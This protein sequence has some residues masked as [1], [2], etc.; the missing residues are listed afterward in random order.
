MMTAI[1]INGNC[2]ILHWLLIKNATAFRSE[3]GL[4]SLDGVIYYEW[5]TGSLSNGGEKPEIQKPGDVDAVGVRQ[6]IR[7]DRV[8]Y[9]DSNPWPVKADGGGKCL[10]RKVPADYGNDVVNWQASDPSPG[11]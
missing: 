1:S 3:F 7:I 8:S 2:L 5:L 6:Y 4:T 9:D 10:E 11:G